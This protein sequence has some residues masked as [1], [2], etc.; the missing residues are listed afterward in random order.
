MNRGHYFFLFIKNF[1]ILKNI[2]ICNFEDIAKKKARKTQI[3]NLTK[4]FKKKIFAVQ[5]ILIQQ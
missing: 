4:F 5:I 3:L 2:E 1:T